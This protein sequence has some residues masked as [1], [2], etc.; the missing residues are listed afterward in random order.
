MAASTDRSKWHPL[1]TALFDHAASKPGAVLTHPWGHSVFGVGGKN[2]VFFGNPDQP[3][4]T[5]KPY[6]G[7]RDML[8]A[9]KKAEVAHYIG[10]YG[11]V[12]MHVETRQQLT[13][14]LDLIDESYEHVIS[15]RAREA[16][17]RQAAARDEAKPV[18]KKRV[19]KAKSAG[20]SRK[21]KG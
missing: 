12:D 8:I 14:A 7:S 20:R 16:A 17:A 21:P 9:E 6:P 5:V 2:F 15:K 3:G 19:T 4:M 10:R 1:Y 18:P 11:W 13:L